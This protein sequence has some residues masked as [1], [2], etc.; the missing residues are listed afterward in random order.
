[1]CAFPSAAYDGTI[2]DAAKCHLRFAV[3]S[4]SMDA[5]T[6]RRRN[7]KKTRK[8]Y[9]CD[10]ALAAS[11]WRNETTYASANDEG[12]DAR[13][14]ASIAGA[15]AESHGATP[16]VDPAIAAAHAPIAPHVTSAANVAAQ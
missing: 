12:T 2:A 8:K 15:A 9:I 5:T 10:D 4:S 1:M 11:S 3:E 14:D 13:S 6:A 16:T 7:A